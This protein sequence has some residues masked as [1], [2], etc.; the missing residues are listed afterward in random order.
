LPQTL[1][2]AILVDDPIAL[3]Q[4]TQLAVSTASPFRR[5]VYGTAAEHIQVDV[6]QTPA[7]V[8]PA[9]DQCW[10]VSV[11]PVGALATLAPVEVATRRALDILHHQRHRIRIVSPDQK[12]YVVAGDHIVENV[13]LVLLRRFTQALDIVAPVNLKLQQE[14]TFLTAMRNVETAVLNALN[15]PAKH[16][17]GPPYPIPAILAILRSYHVLRKLKCNIR[18]QKSPIRPKYRPF[19]K[20]T[21][22][23]T[24]Y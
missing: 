6:E 22:A 7:Q 21:C 2:Q 4:T 16:P 11:S 19:Q 5:M 8:L 18:Y 12:V 15:S 1:Q 24:T 10:M 9:L 23:L 20:L 3:A 17:K 13:Q 14:S